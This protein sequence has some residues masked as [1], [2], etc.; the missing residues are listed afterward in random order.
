[1]LEKVVV[2]AGELTTPAC[3]DEELEASELSDTLPRW[4]TYR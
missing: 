1:M 3:S 2:A 4:A